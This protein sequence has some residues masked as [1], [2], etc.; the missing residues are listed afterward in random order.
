MPNSQAQNLP[1]NFEACVSHIKRGEVVAFPTETVYGLGADASN[2]SAVRKVFETKGRPS[3]NPLIVHI[4]DISQ[5]D[6]LV[7]DISDPVRKLMNQCWPGPLTLVLP[8]QP[9][10]LDLV[11]AGLN[12]VAVRMP[13]HELA[14][15]FIERTGPLVAPSANT[16]G[17]PSPTKAQHVRDDFGDQVE[18]LDG[19]PC[20]IGLES[21][22]LDVTQEPY[23]ILRPGYYGAQELSRIAGLAVRSHSKSISDQTD[24]SIPKSPGTKYTHYTPQAQVRWIRP[25][26]TP[27]SSDQILY[28][29]HSPSSDQSKTSNII[30]FEEIPQMAAELFDRFRQADHEGFEEVVIQPFEKEQ[31]KESLVEALLNRIEKAIGQ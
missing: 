10:V 26:E 13:K 12:S 15:A 8:K 14:L 31:S 28:L 1:N 9:Q 25:G 27:T 5:L 17:K 23:T 20:Q 29:I 11:T 18:V 3:D 7:T 30:I 4:S 16:S 24:T 6:D 21:T 22:V 19:G 2:P